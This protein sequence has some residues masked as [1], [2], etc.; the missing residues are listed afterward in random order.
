MLEWEWFSDSSTLSVFMFLLLSANL[1]E[2]QWQ[3]VTIMPGQLVTSQES[4]SAKTKLSRQQVRTSLNRLK[5]TSEITISTTNKYTL[6]TIVKWGSYQGSETNDN[7]Q[8]NQPCNQRTTNEQPTNNQRITTNKKDKNIENE[9][10]GEK[11]LKPLS[12]KPDRED[13]KPLDDTDLSGECGT[14]PAVAT[15]GKTSATVTVREVVAYLNQRCGTAF[16]A[17][18]KDTQKHINARLKEGFTI[19][20]FFIVIDKKAFEWG[21]SPNMAQYLRPQTLF[22]T[23]F[24]SY[25]NQ[26]WTTGDR[27]N[28]TQLTAVRILAEE[29][30]KNRVNDACND[31]INIPTGGCNHDI[32]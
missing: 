8:I 13:E 25:L 4:I 6:I 23:K 29:N 32:G 24:E 7:Q 27:L 2:R 30:A 10:K 9:K 28:E 15:S 18:T 1:R 11:Y 22:A 5:S 26:P 19:D 21:N 31:V 17:T 20:D 16:R 12:G 14:T 3:G